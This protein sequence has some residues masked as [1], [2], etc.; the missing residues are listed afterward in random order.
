MLPL[1]I[2]SIRS[3]TNAVTEEAWE[4]GIVSAG[5]SADR[6]PVFQTGGRGFESH[7]APVLVYRL[8]FLTNVGSGPPYSG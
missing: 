4:T 8:R 7:L 5:S 3:T 2:A 6:A 1:L